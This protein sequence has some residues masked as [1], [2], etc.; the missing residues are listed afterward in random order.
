MSAHLYPGSRPPSFRQFSFKPKLHTH[1]WQRPSG[2][3]PATPGVYPQKASRVHLRTSES[4]PT[5]RGSC[6]SSCAHSERGKTSSRTNRGR[7]RSPG[8]P[9]VPQED[10]KDRIETAAELK[11]WYDNFEALAT[12]EERR[13][14]ALLEQDAYTKVGVAIHMCNDGPNFITELSAKWDKQSNGEV[15]KA[16]FRL[17]VK[18]PVPQ[19]LGLTTMDYKALDPLFDSLDRDKSGSLETKGARSPVYPQPGLCP[20]TCALLTMAASPCP[21]SVLSQSLKPYLRR[22][23]QRQY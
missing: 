20:C 1:E 11:R 21:C 7:S 19:G 17:G 3:N 6:S 14:K 10:D 5:I 9:K 16:E 8:K 12:A 15:K 4:L 18:S 2:G 22:C 23:K 13:G